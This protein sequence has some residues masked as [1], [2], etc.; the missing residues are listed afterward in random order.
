MNAPMET[1]FG[2]LGGLAVF[3]F[4]MNMMSEGLQKAAGAKMKSILSLLTSNPVLGVLAGAVATAVLQSSSATT[5]MA[6]GFVSAR[7]MT[8]RQAIA[9][10]FGANIGT[11]MTAQLMAFKLSD[12]IWLIVFVGFIVW[13]I[14][15]DERIKNIGQTVFAFGLLFVGI[16]T[17]GAVMKPLAQ[18]EVFLAMIE[19][20]KDIPALGVVVGTVM[21]LVVQSSSATIAVLQSFASQAGPDGVTSVLGLAGSIPILLGDNIGTTITALLASIGQ[22]RDAK[23]TAVAH[24]VFN[25][26]GALVFIWF[27]PVIVQ[28]VQFLTPGPELDVIARQIANAH[29]TFNVVCTL[30]WLPFIGVMVKI[31]TFLVP[32]KAGAHDQG[33]LVN[34]DDKIVGQPVFAIRMF[35]EELQ[36]YC[37]KVRDML[38]ALPEA[39][40]NKDAA[41]L[42]ALKADCA[43]VEAAETELANYA[44]ELLSAGATSEKQAAEISDLMFIVDAVGRIGARCGEVSALYS[45]RLSSKKQF[46]DEARQELGESAAMVAEMYGAVLQFL[47]DQDVASERVLDERRRQIIKRQSKARKDHFR[48]VSSQQC[49]PENK[50]VYNQLLL[51]LERAGNECSNLVEHGAELSMWGDSLGADRTDSRGGGSG[52]LVEALA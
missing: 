12:Y 10:I 48:R 33:A 44:V 45:E 29:T 39:I 23:R 8:M 35:G 26:S 28:F 31:V 17:M 25:I 3:L 38:T 42:K 46:S 43:T 6:I 9:V 15:K 11:T 19:Q 2:L 7:L 40:A 20:V 13:F 37:E 14:A 34:L 50:A 32:G 5:V 36:K 27:V 41:A 52:E 24:S 47:S 51:C 49:A 30:L 21:T 16:D 22:S 1:V 18:S 4:G